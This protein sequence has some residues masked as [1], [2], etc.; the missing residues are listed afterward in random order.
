MSAH[1]EGTF[2]VK[3]W[4]ENAYQELDDGTKLTKATM[5]FD[6]GGDVTAEGVSDSVMYYRS[7]G[8]AVFTGLQRMVGQLDGHDGSFVLHADGEYAGGAATTRW[9]IV[10]GSGTGA[11]TGLRG[12]GQ[13]VAASGNPGGTFTLDYDL[14]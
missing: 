9:Q 5:T 3:A 6:F 11:L 12:S 7:D 13:A 8:T 10:D 2:T 1:A 4:D 14:A